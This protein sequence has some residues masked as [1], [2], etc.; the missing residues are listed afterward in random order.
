MSASA[1]RWLK[2][3][4][5]FVVTLGAVAGAITAVRALLPA[6]DPPDPEDSAQ[7]TVEV[8]PDMPLSEYAQRQNF[9]APLLRLQPPGT[10]PGEEPGA[11]PGTEPTT[12]D[13]VRERTCVDCGGEESA[14]NEESPPSSEDALPG[15]DA[16]TTAPPDG[17][18]PGFPGE[19]ENNEVCQQTPWDCETI[20]GVVEGAA[21]DENG[22]QVDPA[23]QA[24]R[25][26]EIIDDARKSSGGEPVGVLVTVDAVLVGLRDEPVQLRWAM[27]QATGGGRLHGGWL[28]DH[29]VYRMRPDTDRDSATVDLWI[30]LPKT[31]GPFVVDVIASAGGAD[32]A[33]DRSDGFD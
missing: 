33:K 32:L 26:L 22:N 5:A 27:W 11:E 29:L 1:R 31:A 23:V 16:R 28:N 18:E 7:V 6:A 13:T 14:I 3:A 25:V 2:R 19:S 20:G 9:A 8:I 24:R 15:I 21:T 4:V 10:E 12:E 30:P 17:E